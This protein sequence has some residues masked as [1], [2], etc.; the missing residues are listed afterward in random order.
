VEFYDCS[1]TLRSHHSAAG[2]AF[3]YG[4]KLVYAPR[5]KREKAA[6]NCIHPFF[7]KRIK[8]RIDKV[9]FIYGRTAKDIKR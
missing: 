2:F 1:Q 4:N 5:G 6:R 9:D 8:L 3:S 7:A